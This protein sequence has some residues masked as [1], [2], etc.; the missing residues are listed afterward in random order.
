MNLLSSPGNLKLFHSGDKKIFE[1]VFLAN[2]QL[3]YREA[4]LMLRD[5]G[6]AEDV[7][8]EMYLKLW[9]KK[10]DLNDDGHVKAFLLRA[11]RNKCIDILRQR[12]RS[13][14]VPGGYDHQADIQD[15]EGTGNMFHEK[16]EEGVYGLV[17][18]AILEKMKD[19][20]DKCRELARLILIEGLPV[21]EAARVMG[22]KE[23]T[24]Y[25]QWAKAKKLLRAALRGR[26][27]FPMIWL[28]IL[29]RPFF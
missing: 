20:P 16:V 5:S 18:G 12:Q 4:W 23:S 19:M 9:N 7:V 25:T 14:I 3:L 22:I 8:A 13:P 6:E 21:R 24:A 28:A 29:C 17:L 15:T 2:M 1:Q 11:A 26:D 10:E 27:L